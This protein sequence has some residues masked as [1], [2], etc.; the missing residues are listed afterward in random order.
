MIAAVTALLILTATTPSVEAPANFGLHSLT[1]GFGRGRLDSLGIVS[2]GTGGVVHLPREPMSVTL[3][4]SGEGVVTV[5]AADAASSVVA[6]DAP[7]A[8]RLEL[9]QGGDLRIES[10]RRVRLRS[11]TVER[12]ER[13]TV[14]VALV[15]VT[16]VV[17]LALAWRS[18]I[19]ALGGL[20]MLLLGAGVAFHGT[21]CWTFLRIGVGRAVPGMAIAAVFFPLVVAVRNATWPK[22]LEATRLPALAFVLTLALTLI[23]L[24]LFTQPLPLGDPAAYLDM[25]DKYAAAIRKA[26]VPLDLGPALLDLRPYLALPATGILYGLLRLFTDGLALIYLVQAFAM[27]VSVAAVVSI[28]E[29]EAGP[30]PAR[31]ALGLCLL[32]PTIAII[33]GIVQPEPFI[34]A[35]WTLAAMAALRALRGEASPTHFVTVGILAGGGLGLHPQGLSFLLLAALLCVLPWLPSTFRHPERAAGVV[36]GALGV[37]LPIT[38]AESFSKPAAHVLDEKYGFFAYTSPHPL[39]FWLYTDSD[40]WQGPLRIDETTY[41][42]E[43]FASKGSEAT[44]SSYADVAAFAARH[45]RVSLQTLLTNLHRLWHQPDNPFAVPFVLPYEGQ[46][47]AHRAAIVLFV[48]SI[49]RLASGATALIVLPFAILAMTYPGYHIFNKYA[50]PALPFVLMGAAIALDALVRERRRVLWGALAAAAIGALMPASAAARVGLDGA[51]FLLL[52]RGALWIGLLVA[53]FITIRA[54]G[55]DRRARSVSALIGT[56]VLIGSSVSASLSDTERA[57][58]AASLETPVDVSCHAPTA[59]PGESTWLLIDARSAS[60]RP[61]R[62][63]VNGRALEAEATMPTFGLATYRG[64]REATTLRQVWRVPLAPDLASAELRIRIAGEPGDSF[65]GD[66][67]RGGEGPRLSAGMWPHVSVYRLMHESQYRLPVF[68]TPPQACDAAGY[69]GRPGV[70]LVRMKPWAESPFA[71]RLSSPPTRVF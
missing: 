57:T 2:D 5:R 31:I 44:K 52:V 41:Q 69:S 26:S 34:L 53:L 27:A 68:D 20:V 16:G 21:L 64:H 19:G 8:V 28:C 63:S 46:V 24:A 61:P 13:S 4:L 50:T 3:R 38:V 54:W 6:A 23:Q 12:R 65:Y 49:A 59:V 9:P 67:R 25:G 30:R 10:G 33:P 22:R 66:L 35:A 43:L 71:G 14:R 11:M 58:W 32:H 39:G 36:V 60:G 40:G 1:E 55:G 42:K 70:A 47:Q 48:L 37:L 62:I 56:V 18:T 17:A 45:P 29:S 51:L 15:A 7:V